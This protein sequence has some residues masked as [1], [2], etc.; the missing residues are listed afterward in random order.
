MNEEK[1][2]YWKQRGLRGSAPG[3]DCRDNEHQWETKQTKRRSVYSEDHT[4][5]TS[6]IESVEC[7]K[8][9]SLKVDE[10][11][12]VFGITC[13]ELIELGKLGT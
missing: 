12:I 6:C 9:G 4:S 11:S 3:P 2:L 8:C 10:T 7:A 13:P 5:I 1:I